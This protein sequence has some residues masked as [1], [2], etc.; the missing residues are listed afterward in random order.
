MVAVRTGIGRTPVDAYYSELRINRYYIYKRRHDSVS[1]LELLPLFHCCLVEALKSTRD[2][3]W[4]LPLYMLH[5]FDASD[6]C[7][8]VSDMIAS[9]SCHSRVP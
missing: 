1:D 7:F 8:E 6:H 4:A 2:C 5:I 3:A 9:N